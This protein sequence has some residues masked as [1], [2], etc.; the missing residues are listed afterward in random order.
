M[1]GGSA[2]VYNIGHQ[3]RTY[4]LFNSQ[5][6]H[7]GFPMDGAQVGIGSHNPQYLNPIH[8]YH[9]WLLS[10]IIQRCHK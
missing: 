1:R 6:N 10:F 4:F 8:H 5:L 9:S 2:N 3:G 7:D